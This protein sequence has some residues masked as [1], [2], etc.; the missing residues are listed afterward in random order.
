MTKGLNV[1]EYKELGEEELQLMLLNNQ[2]NI[3]ELFLDDMM[4]RV[5][6]C[7]RSQMGRDAA[8]EMEDIA[9]DAMMIVY[10]GLE[11]GPRNVR[12]FLIG[13]VKNLIKKRFAE[14]TKADSALGID[15]SNKNNSIGTQVAD[16]MSHGD[17]LKVAKRKVGAF[18]EEQRQ[19]MKT[20]ES[21]RNFSCQLL[22]M[23]EIMFRESSKPAKM[24]MA[25]FEAGGAKASRI[26]AEAALYFSDLANSSTPLD[27]DF[28]DELCLAWV[29]LLGA[30]PVTLPGRENVVSDCLADYD[31][32]VKLHKKLGCELCAEGLEETPELANVY[33]EAIRESISPTQK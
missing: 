18:V 28:I 33:K 20:H 15:P 7:I 22:G 25:S 16:N 4:K 14:R 21:S 9:Q 5:N 11:S 27:I 2:A 26:K 10:T 3:W 12:A 29:D 19:A 6:A 31:N 1:E 24:F 32:L 13:V 8:Q 17:L 23:C 30:C